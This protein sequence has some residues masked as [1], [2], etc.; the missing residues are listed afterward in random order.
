[1][2]NKG[3]SPENY[4]FVPGTELYTI[5]LY[6]KEIKK[7]CPV[8]KGKKKL[9][10]PEVKQSYTCPH[11]NGW[12]YKI[13]NEPEK[14]HL[15]DYTKILT[16]INIR[17]ENKTEE[18]PKKY[19]IKRENKKEEIVYFF[20]CNGYKLENVFLSRTEALREVERRNKKLQQIQDEK[21]AL[22]VYGN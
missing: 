3:N 11:C 15:E 17:R 18:I 16:Q 7:T 10:F 9:T 5:S 4:I 1:M 21:E 2:K 13:E 20:G 8:C 22:E 6:R 14:W 19:S 12:G